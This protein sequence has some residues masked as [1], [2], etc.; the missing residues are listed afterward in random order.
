[1]GLAALRRRA[2]LTQVE[3]AERM[4]ITQSDL[5]KLER[6]HDIRLSTLDAYAR[7]V[8]G[9]LHLLISFREEDG[10]VDVGSR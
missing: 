6:R 1:M 8:G 3:L 4:G 5:S 9:K 2:G 7:A 10:E